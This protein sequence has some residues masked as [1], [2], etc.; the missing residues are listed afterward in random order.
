MNLARGMVTGVV[1]LLSIGQGGANT[2]AT[3]QPTP[4]EAFAQLPATHIAW[5]S[6]VGRIDSSEAHAI[7]T[8][9]IL[10]DTAQPPDRM[11]GVRVHLSSRDSQDDVYLGEETLG[12]YKNALDQISLDAASER[13]QG[14][15][16]FN[17]TA[18]GTTY[19][20]AQV[21]W[22]A[23]KPARVHALNATYY[24]GPESS[25]LSVDAFRHVGFRFPNQDPS[26]LSMAI[27]A[28]IDQLK[29][30]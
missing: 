24:I 8:A 16:R 27:A 26:R 19:V 4:L 30:R 11:R 6:E 12:V 18:G 15:S 13:S 21:F 29:T 20:G 2:G 22:Y 10:E 5:S 23:D 7:V 1:L 17:L 28:A 3:L 25:G 14:N 9:L